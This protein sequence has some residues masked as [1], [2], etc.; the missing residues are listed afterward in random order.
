VN[1]LAH[2]Y[3]SGNDPNIQLGNF[4]G[5]FVKGRNLAEQFEANVARGIELHR[6]IDEFTD[7]HPVV[8]LSKVRLRD[9]YRHYAPVIVDIF[10]DHYLARNWDRFHKTF[11]PDFAE[12]TYNMIMSREDI[13]PE[14]VK[15]MMPYMIKGNWLANYA[16]IDGIG[17]VLNGMSRRTPY[18]S[19]MHEAV[20]D[21]QVHYQ[22]FENEFF[23]FF[24]E[25]E[26]H[27]KDFL[28]LGTMV[29]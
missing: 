16:R 17:R 10:Y 4:I 29:N 12:Q 7:R 6:A 11:L 13:L 26:K 8:K 24:P 18:D 22:E 19:K 28:E 5:D 2:I 21:L 15:W 27:S 1:F 20:E 14:K 23:D 3:L 9:K 25:L